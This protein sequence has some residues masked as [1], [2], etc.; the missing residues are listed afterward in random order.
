MIAGLISLKVCNFLTTFFKLCL[1]LIFPDSQWNEST[2]NFVCRGMNFSPASKNSSVTLSSLA[3]RPLTKSNTWLVIDP[4]LATSWSEVLFAFFLFFLC[5]FFYFWFQFFVI[6]FYLVSFLDCWFALSSVV[7][8][9]YPLF[10][11][12][13]NEMNGWNK[14]EQ[15]KWPL[16][17]WSVSEHYCTGSAA[18]P[19]IYF[20]IAQITNLPFK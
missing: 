15:H 5:S 8:T 1:L 19:D 7:F 14:I 20:Y 16:L 4:M 9:S 17:K 13:T 2:T 6:L 10:F 3:G 12:G 11:F 18:Y